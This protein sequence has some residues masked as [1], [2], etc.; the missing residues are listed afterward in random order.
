VSGC[1]A[2]R[3]RLPGG[4]VTWFVTGSR[5]TWLV[6]MTPLPGWLN[7][8]VEPEHIE[9]LQESMVKI[10]GLP[11]TPPFAANPVCNAT[12]RPVGSIEVKLID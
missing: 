5:P 11:E 2:L 12:N 4:V 6:P 9:V 8:T 1:V 10:T 7:S 3:P